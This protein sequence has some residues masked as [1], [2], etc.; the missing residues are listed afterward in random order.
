MDYED[1]LRIIADLQARVEELEAVAA[2]NPFKGNK[3]SAF[4]S[5]ELPMH[6]D[7]GFRTDTTWVVMNCNGTLRYWSVT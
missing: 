6:G 7:Y 2:Y 1:L 3:G 4:T 5:A